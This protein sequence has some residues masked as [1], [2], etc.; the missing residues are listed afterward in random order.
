[1]KL[2]NFKPAYIIITNYYFI[3]FLT[4]RGFVTQMNECYVALSIRKDEATTQASNIS[5]G[6]ES[7]TTTTIA[8]T[9]T[10]TQ[11]K[12]NLGLES[13]Q[14]SEKDSSQT[15]PVLGMIET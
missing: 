12:N 11:L 8:T 9:T 5:G 15:L 3:H 1:M 2:D 10:T 4:K 14:K 13:N 7:T 6:A